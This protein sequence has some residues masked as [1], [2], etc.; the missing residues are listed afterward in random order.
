MSDK[1]LDAEREQALR[2]HVTEHAHEY[3]E[4][5]ETLAL[6]ATLDAERRERGRRVEGGA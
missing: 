1:P 3:Q 4:A 6:F 2:D 5:A